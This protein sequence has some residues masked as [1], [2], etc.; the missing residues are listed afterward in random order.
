VS[1]GVSAQL[2]LVPGPADDL[3]RN[4]HHRPDGNIVV[5]RGGARLVKRRPHEAFVL[6]T[7]GRS[8]LRH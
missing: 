4:H 8:L 7:G 1:G 3:A 5:S 2:P 6:G